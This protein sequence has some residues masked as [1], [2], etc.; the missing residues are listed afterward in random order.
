ME[1]TPTPQYVPCG[2][3]R[4]GGTPSRAILLNQDLRV[5]GDSSRASPVEAS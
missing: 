1:I 3:G 4:V 5:A 2:Q